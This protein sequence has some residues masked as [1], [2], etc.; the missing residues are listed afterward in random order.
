MVHLPD[1]RALAETC[2]TIGGC[3]ERGLAAA[4]ASLAIDPLAPETHA[5]LAKFLEGKAAERAKKVSAALAGV[6][7]GD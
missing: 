2:A 6:P 7:D 5:V 4:K 3:E 1:L